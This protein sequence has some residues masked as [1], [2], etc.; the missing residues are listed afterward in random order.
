MI[1]SRNLIFSKKNNRGEND[2][3]FGNLCDKDFE[4]VRLLLGS[5]L[6]Y[7]EIDLDKDH[8]NIRLYSGRHFYKTMLNAGGLGKDIEEFFM[9]QRVSND[10]QKRYNHKDKTGK[11][12]LVKKIELMFSIIDKTF[13]N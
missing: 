5:L 1:L 2:Y 3:I 8:K 11:E 4:R 13:F 6:G 12:N 10:M 9:G 7:S